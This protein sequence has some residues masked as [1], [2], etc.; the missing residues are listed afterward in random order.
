MNTNIIFRTY[1]RTGR[2][3]TTNPITLLKILLYANME[4]I[5]SS[6]A[7]ESS[8]NRDINFIWLLNG[9]KAPS[10]HEIARFRSQRLSE[11]AEELFYELVGKQ[12]YSF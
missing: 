6:R 2:K 11:C 5:Y 9:A 1:K 10:H 7:I 8:C 4:G 3:P 12:N